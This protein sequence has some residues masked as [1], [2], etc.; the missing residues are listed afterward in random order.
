MALGLRPMARMLERPG[1]RGELEAY[2]G[3]A[4][5]ALRRYK[6]ATGTPVALLGQSGDRLAHYE[7]LDLA[8]GRQDGPGD[9]DE[10]GRQ[11]GALLGYP[12]CCVQAFDERD[13]ERYPLAVLSRSGRGP[14]PFENNFLYHL[15]SRGASA[16]KLLAHGYDAADAFL[17]AWV[18]CRFE[19]DES[20]RFGRLMLEVLQGFDKAFA[21]A[22]KRRLLAEVR[23]WD[24][25]RF[26]AEGVPVKT[27]L[28]SAKAHSEP[29]AV[30]RFG[31]AA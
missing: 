22:L 23:Y 29:A 12:P 5:L 10:M 11:L 25:T 28:S 24:E 9:R 6:D 30:F 1:T 8:K 21:A 18:P 26:E 14:F 2:A 4:G 20:R 13:H 3:A 7:P 31:E 19:C 16:A 15:A 27:L 17:I